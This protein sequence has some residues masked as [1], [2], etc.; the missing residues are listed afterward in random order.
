MKRWGTNVHI[1]YYTQ[2]QALEADDL[3][4]MSTEKSLKYDIIMWDEWSAT[5]EN[6]SLVY[7]HF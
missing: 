2:T 7:T 6:K 4:K 3:K 1:L 5:S